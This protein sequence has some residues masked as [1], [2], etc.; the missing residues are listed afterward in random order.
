MTELFPEKA[1]A[2][3]LAHAYVALALAQDEAKR[4]AGEHSAHPALSPLLT[5]LDITA[6]VLEE[7]LRDALPPDPVSS[8][9]QPITCSD[10]LM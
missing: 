7:M 9:S 8:P 5:C 10:M 1:Y 4:Y 2:R 6:H 3:K